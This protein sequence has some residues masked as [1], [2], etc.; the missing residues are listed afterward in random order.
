MGRRISPAG[1]SLVEVLVAL[2][3]AAILSLA[4]I[5]AQR[6]AFEMAENGIERWRCLDLAM[7]ILAENP[8]SRLSTPTGGWSERALPPEGRW[9]L[10]REYLPHAGSWQILTLKSGETQLRFEWA[11]SNLAPT[12]Q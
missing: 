5:A 3:V 9:K 6:R 1:F 8:T 10:E 7:A 11:D 4:L 12:G 2:A